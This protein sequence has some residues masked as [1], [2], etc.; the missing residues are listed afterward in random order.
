MTAF[1]DLVLRIRGPHGA[2]NGGD[3]GQLDAEVVNATHQ[4]WRRNSLVQ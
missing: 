1:L 2:K 3:G 4:K